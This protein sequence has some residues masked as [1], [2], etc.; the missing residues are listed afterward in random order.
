[1]EETSTHIIRIDRLLQSEPYVSMTLEKSKQLINDDLLETSEVKL[2][3]LQ[4]SFTAITSRF[5]KAAGK[6]C[7][8]TV[9][10]K[11]T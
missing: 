11:E 5:A 10:K 4:P 6:L 9:K 2:L 7:V 3:R 1:M 8:L